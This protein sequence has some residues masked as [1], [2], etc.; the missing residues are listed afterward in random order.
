MKPLL[1]LLGLAS[2]T[3]VTTAIAKP[4]PT[5]QT[6]Q[7]MTTGGAASTKWDG[8]YTLDMNQAMNNGLSCPGFHESYHYHPTH[9]PEPV[10]TVKGGKI[11]LEIQIINPAILVM[12]V[13]EGCFDYAAKKQNSSDTEDPKECK[14]KL[15]KVAAAGFSTEP[16]LTLGTLVVTIDKAG[17]AY[18]ALDIQPPSVPDVP[19]PDRSDREFKD[20][21]SRL[22]KIAVID[23]DPDRHKGQSQFEANA[24]GRDAY[25]TISTLDDDNHRSSCSFFMSD[26]K[27]RYKA[28]PANR[29]GACRLD[30]DCHGSMTCVGDTDGIHYT[31]TCH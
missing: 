13:N 25:I 11:K 24:Q 14:D 26:Y 7:T 16:L 31:G 22:T 10:Y 6:G 21:M 3:F 28:N 30:S 4:T 23:P 12:G 2:S 29:S 17:H 5:D 19:D 15:A 27:V 20:K 18:G 8:K 1:A 9:E